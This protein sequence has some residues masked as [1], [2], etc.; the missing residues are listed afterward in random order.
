MD[1]S[2]SQPARFEALVDYL[3]S[4]AETERGD[5]ARELHDNLG[6]LLVAA[7]MDMAWIQQNR[8]PIA[9]MP[10][11]L[12][13]VSDSLRSG[14]DLKRQLVE[15]LQPSLLREVGLYSALGWLMRSLCARINVEHE[16]D[17]VAP[18]PL[19][20]NGTPIE[21][22]R[23]A[24]EAIE[25]F[26]SQRKGELLVLGGYHQDRHFVIELDLDDDEAVVIANQWTRSPRFMSITH[27]ARRLNAET[28]LKAIGDSRLQFKLLLPVE[29]ESTV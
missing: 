25:M 17:F 6:G 29:M 9:D 19:L 1:G 23:I 16:E 12:G 5:L 10:M 18:E 15:R 7:M 27:R 4:R 24:Q 26:L 11:R 8:D 2:E 21:V 22:Y 13:R 14:I 28:H 20:K 3:H